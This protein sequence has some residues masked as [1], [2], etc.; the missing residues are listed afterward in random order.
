MTTDDSHAEHLIS[1]THSSNTTHS[2]DRHN[3]VFGGGIETINTL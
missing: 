2:F 3:I 1:L